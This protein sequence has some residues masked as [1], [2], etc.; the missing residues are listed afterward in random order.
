MNTSTMVSPPNWM[1]GIVG[2]R[3]AEPPESMSSTPP[4]IASTPSY[5]LIGCSSDVDGPTMITLGPEPQVAASDHLIFD[6]MLDTPHRNVVVVTIFLEK[7]LDAQVPN[8]RTHVRVWVND[9]R[10]PNQVSISVGA[11]VRGV[12]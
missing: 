1:I 7:L 9:L 8:T 6:G 3:A 4:R 10:Y 12:E 2:S 11:V 5:I